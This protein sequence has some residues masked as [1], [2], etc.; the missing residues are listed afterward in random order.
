MFCFHLSCY[1]C[2]L[3]FKIV[4]LPQ[5]YVYELDEDG[6]FRSGSVDEADNFRSGVIRFADGAKCEDLVVDAV[7]F[8]GRL[9]DD[10]ISLRGRVNVVPQD[11]YSIRWAKDSLFSEPSYH[12]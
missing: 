10:Q 8:R 6:K 5:G 11:G 7:L 12:H 2:I 1:V 3:L 9:L 4:S